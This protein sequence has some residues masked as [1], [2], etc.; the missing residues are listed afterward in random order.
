MKTSKHARHP[1]DREW[2][3]QEAKNRLSQVVESALHDGPQTIT[4]RGKPTAVVVSCEEFRQM[5]R[6]RTTLAQFFQDSPLHGVELDLG[7]GPD[8]PR[9]VDL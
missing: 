1:H 2:Q 6:Q 9:E 7:L 5:T 4:L 8:L 3:L